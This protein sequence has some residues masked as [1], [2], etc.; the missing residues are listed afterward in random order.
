MTTLLQGLSY[1][2]VSLYI[3]S[4]TRA[5]S[6]PLT[7][8]IVLSVF[9]S[10][11]VVGQI[12]LGH[13][14]DIFPYPWVMLASALGSGTVAFLLWGLAN[15]ATQLYFFAVIFGALVSRPL[16]PQDVTSSRLTLWHASQSGGFSSTWPRAAS[17]CARGKPEYAGLALA[18]T[19]IFKGISAIIGPILSGVLLE[20]GKG[21]AIG[22]VFG[23]EGYGAVEIF[24]GSCALAT[25]AGSILVARASQRARV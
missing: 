5:L 6:S 9:N 18:S 14:S 24:V 2:P 15:A 25:G 10:S 12:V 22:G 8:T 19:A 7:A 20:A 11:A 16:P 23:R 4:F 21:A 3:A 1:F 13:L 17:D